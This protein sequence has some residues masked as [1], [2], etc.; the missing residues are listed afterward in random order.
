MHGLV[1]AEELF[2]DTRVEFHA[3]N[4]HPDL[5]ALEVRLA[6]AP[7]MR[8]D[9]VDDGAERSLELGVLR[10]VQPRLARGI[11]HAQPAA[12]REPV[13]AIGAGR[14]L[15]GRMDAFVVLASIGIAQR[16]IVVQGIGTRLEPQVHARQQRRQRIGLQREAVGLRQRMHRVAHVHGH[17]PLAVRLFQEIVQQRLVRAA[18]PRPHAGLRQPRFGGTARLRSFEQPAVHRRTAPGRV[19]VGVQPRIQGAV[20]SLFQQNHE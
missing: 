11:A 20:E 12:R 5:Q 6:H 3:R 13:H 1:R 19:V 2:V 17:Q 16:H 8:A 14:R 10:R 18:K 4:I 9:R 7:G 15:V